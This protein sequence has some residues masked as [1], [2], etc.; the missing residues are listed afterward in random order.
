MCLSPL[1]LRSG[2]SSPDPPITASNPGLVVRVCL[3]VNFK[4]EISKGKAQ[5]SMVAP[6]WWGYEGPSRMEPAE[7]ELLM[8]TVCLTVLPRKLLW[9]AQAR[10]C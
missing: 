2:V 7:A 3:T 4:E 10:V 6:Q 9:Q 8:L 5:L 1:L